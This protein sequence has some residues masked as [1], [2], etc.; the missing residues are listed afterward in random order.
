MVLTVKVSFADQ[1][2]NTPL[3]SSAAAPSAPAMASAAEA[4]SDNAIAIA[5]VGPLDILSGSGGCVAHSLTM[6][7]QHATLLLTHPP[8]VAVATAIDDLR[9][10]RDAGGRAVDGGESSALGKG[11]SDDLVDRATMTPTPTHIAARTNSSILK[12]TL[13][14]Y[15]RA[16]L[17]SNPVSSAD[18]I[19]FGQRPERNMLESDPRAGEAIVSFLR[20]YDYELKSES[21]AEY[22]YYTARPRYGPTDIGTASLPSNAGAFH[23]ELISPATPHQISRAMPSLGHVLI[24]ETPELYREVVEPY[25]RSVVDNGSLSWINNVIEG[26][27]E[28]ERLLVDHD[29]FIINVD[30]KWRSHPPPLTTPREEWRGHP[31]TSDL[32]CLGIT[33]RRGLSC[34]RDLRRI[35]APMLTAMERAGLDAIR[36]VYGVPED[37][38]RVYAHYQP[39]FYHFHVHFTRLENEVGCCV[40]RGHLVSDVVQNLMMDDAYYAGRTITYKLP[41]GTPLLSLIEGCLSRSVAGRE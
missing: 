20:G 28:R 22:G 32:Y 41:R 2:V 1:A 3:P 25:V 36:D 24:R 40:E 12:L 31:S 38:I 13:V 39:Q 18:G 29:D 19:E 34:I 6:S 8:T 33:K 17:G 16:I 23:V 10:D 5:V 30:T 11:T 7:D 14:P 21:G 27:K 35:H 15:H 26:R 37:Q 9:T 4:N